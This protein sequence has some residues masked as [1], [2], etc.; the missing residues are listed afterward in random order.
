MLSSF[1]IMYLFP[2]TS[3]KII[4]SILL[5]FPFQILAAPSDHGRIY[6]DNS[7]GSIAIG[8]I[9]FLIVLI[10]WIVSRIPS[11]QDKNTSD[12]RSHSKT[13]QPQIHGTELKRCPDC[14]G[15]GYKTKII[16]S[17]NAPSDY[18]VCDRCKGYKH[19]LN[20]EAKRLLTDYYREFNKEQETEFN[21][22]EE[23]AKRKRAQEREK[24]LQQEKIKQEIR[25]EGRE[26]YS[27]TEYNTKIS[28]LCRTRRNLAL[29]FRELKSTLSECDCHG[30]NK[31]CLRCYGSGYIFNDELRLLMQIYK[32]SIN[33]RQLLTS[34]RDRIYGEPQLGVADFSGIARSHRFSGIASRSYRLDF[35]HYNS[36]KISER[37]TS[38]VETQPICQECM[39]EGILKVIA[40]EYKICEYHI[41]IK[42]TCLKCGGSK[43]IENTK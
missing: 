13:T 31:D 42:T 1:Q 27:V 10:G 2:P 16:T 33:E 25:K 34:D 14:Q 23:E 26:V 8:M 36:S 3:N 12:A 20:E 17:Y 24:E 39:G 35:T 19:E 41:K 43:W 22:R 29:K 40:S 7:P 30:K 4:I 21:R 15:L 9:F 38:I 11:K 6:H 32:L 37:I 28:E 18:I 5:V